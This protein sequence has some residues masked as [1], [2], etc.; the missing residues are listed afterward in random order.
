MLV[1]VVAIRLLVCILASITIVRWWFG[2]Y[3]SPHEICICAAWKTEEGT[4]IR[5]HRHPH[6]YHVAEEMH[7]TPS[8]DPNAQGFITSR[9][10]FVG[11]EEGAKLQKAAGLMD[12]R[13]T[14]CLTSEDLY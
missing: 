13:A 8:R 4:I 11:R 7:L 3:V 5:G 12:P 14:N 10:R 1:V 6:A 2:Y 9:N